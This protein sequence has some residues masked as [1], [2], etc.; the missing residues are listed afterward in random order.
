M[1]RVYLGC[2]APYVATTRALDIAP[3]DSRPAAL[4]LAANVASQFAQAAI[5]VAGQ[6]RSAAGALRSRSVWVW[7]LVAL[8]CVGILGDA[9]TTVLMM[10]T[11]LFEEANGAAASLM[12]VFGLG[13][14][15]TLSGLM[16]LGFA[17]LT[18]A[19]PRSTYAWT[20]ASVAVLICLVKIYTAG[21]N[22]L[23]WWTV[24]S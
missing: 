15:V 12:G 8:W 17:S 22:A 13:G 3:A 9:A 23:L 6:S 7:T 20:A 1:D 16:C 18:L 11:G 14:W 19:R 10:R 5:D 21:S 4:R 2:I 24:T